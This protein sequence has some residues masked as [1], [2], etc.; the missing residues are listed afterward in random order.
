MTTTSDP[1]IIDTVGSAMDKRDAK[2]FY[3]GETFDDLGN[4]VEGTVKSYRN[5][6]EGKQGSTDQKYLKVNV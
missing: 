1:K 5:F 3:G 2:Q 6:P 4:P